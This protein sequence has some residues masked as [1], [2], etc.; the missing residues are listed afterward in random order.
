M[1]KDKLNPLARSMAEDLMSCRA[2]LPLSTAMATVNYKLANIASQ[3]HVKVDTM[4]G[5][6]PTPVNIYSLVLLNSGG[7][8]N[9]SLGLMDRIFFGDAF[10]KIRDVVYPHYKGIALDNLESK[11]VDR[12]LHNWTQS[13]SNAT[14][15]GMFAYAESYSL[16]GFGSLNIEVD[17]ISN[18]VTSKAELFE[19]LLTPYDNGDF[20]P[21]AKRTDPNSM[22]ISGLPVN[23]YCFGNKVRLL[24]GDSTEMSFM[25]LI[26]EGYGRRF[27]FVD[28]NSVPMIKTPEQ[29]MEEM[30]TAEVTRINRKAERDKIADMITSYN[31]NKIIPLSDEAMYQYA[32]IKSESDQYLAQKKGVLP[33]VNADISE[34]YFKTAKLAGVYAFFDGNESVTKE[35]MLE[36]YEV[37]KES[38]EVLD[39]LRKI[40][41]THERLLDA[42]LLEDDGITSQHMLGY[43]FIN[44][45]WTRKIIEVIDLAKQLA[46]ERGYEWVEDTKKGVTYYTV[47]NQE[48]PVGTLF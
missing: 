45:T 2:G 35:N 9:S 48:V 43:S 33:A 29:I 46:S 19:N 16:A 40:K 15:S 18:A 42:M 23:L 44:S 36:A 34:R 27:I 31:F 47:I 21:V 37:V 32:V 25:Q 39:R 14:I 12:E 11:G 24:N 4:S 30:K 38:S 13:I 17:E 20:Q 10:N 6:A 26:D 22:D 8:K 28:D 1:N 7:G 5:Y 41:P 3:L